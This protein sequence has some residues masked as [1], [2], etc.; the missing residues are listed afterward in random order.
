MQFEMKK[1]GISDEALIVSCGLDRLLTCKAGW[2]TSFGAW[3][4]EGR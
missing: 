1:V 2:L 3:A 4:S